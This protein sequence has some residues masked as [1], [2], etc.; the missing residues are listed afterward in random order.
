MFGSQ[1]GT[2]TNNGGSTKPNIKDVRKC[3]TIAIRLLCSLIQDHPQELLD[4]IVNGSECFL[5]VIDDDS[6]PPDARLKELIWTLFNKLSDVKKG[7]FISLS[8]FGGAAFGLDAGIAIVGGSKLHAKRSIESI[9]K[10][11]LIDIDGEMCEIHPLI[12]SFASEKGKNE[13][14][15]ML[16]SSRTRFFEYYINLF[17]NLN[18][19]FL[20][21]D[22][23]SAF[24]MF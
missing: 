14:K 24:K 21:G 15:N 17:E 22:S 16:A 12:Q 6:F 20:K 4:E 5:D 9:K 3:F 23:K 19:R 11:S 10:K 1:V 2:T 18:M 7:A 13:M 8:L